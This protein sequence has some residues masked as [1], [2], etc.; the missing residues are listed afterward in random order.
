MAF[1]RA[2]MMETAKNGCRN[3]GLWCVDRFVFL[4]DDFAPFM[5]ID[6]PGTIQL[7][8]PRGKV[9][10]NFILSSAHAPKPAH[11][12]QTPGYNGYIHVEKIIPQ[13]SNSAEHPRPKSRAKHRVSSVV[14][15]RTPHKESLNRAKRAS[16]SELNQKKTLYAKTKDVARIKQKSSDAEDT[17]CLVRGQTYD[18]IWTQC[19]EY[20]NLSHED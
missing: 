11:L 8:K 13:S 4:D 15:I 19:E 1:P 9:I 12:T 20:K 7:E 17:R 16:Y 5:V 3:S 18:E 10:E 6:R 2:A 14:L